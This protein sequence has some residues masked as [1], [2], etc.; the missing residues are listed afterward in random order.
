MVADRSLPDIGGRDEWTTTGG[1]SLFPIAYSR[2]LRR[3]R[4]LYTLPKSVS[5]GE[6]TDKVSCGELDGEAQVK[7]V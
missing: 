5:E 7:R 6:A 1:I 4:I 3:K 2:V